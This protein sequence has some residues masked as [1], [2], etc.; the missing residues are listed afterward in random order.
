MA[1]RLIGRGALVSSGGR[2][3][4]REIAL[5]LAEEGASV[6][7]NDP[8][9]SGDGQGPSSTLVDQV[10]GE[11][12]G[13]GGVAVPGY[14]NVATMKGGEGVVQL[15]LKRFGRLDILVNSAGG[16]RPRELASMSE[17][18]WSFLITHNLKSVFCPTKFA[19][20]LF[21]QQQSGR[22][23]N[24]TSN[25][26]LGAAGQS[27]DAATSEALV[28][29]TRTVAR[30]MGRYGAT[31]NA[32]VPRAGARGLPGPLGESQHAV[33]TGPGALGDMWQGDDSP[34]DQQN[35][36]LLVAWLCSEAA[37][38][39]NGNVFGVSGGALCL[40]SHPQIEVAIAGPGRLTV[41]QLM[42]LVPRDLGARIGIP[43][44][45]AGAFLHRTGAG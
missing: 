31:C 38:N 32:V 36:A 44:A 19:C 7:V 42:E 37:A 22:I 18:D 4:G 14:E 9:Y 5:L 24:L 35:A 2:G 43:E 8:G 25:A 45:G 23:I 39:V 41:D 27:G 12:K 20:I 21:R 29:F 11:I 1:G 13:R 26:G 40:Y 10:V 16:V 17:N 15:A 33:G 3:L 28:G 34:A 6:V 30:D